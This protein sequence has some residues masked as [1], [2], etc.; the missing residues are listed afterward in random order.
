MPGSRVRFDD[1]FLHIF[2]ILGCFEAPILR[3][4]GTNRC[5]KRCSEKKMRRVMKKGSAGKTVVEAVGPLKQDN[6]T[7]QQ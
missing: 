3:P 4:F 1:E 5:K 2:T 7:A 6:Q